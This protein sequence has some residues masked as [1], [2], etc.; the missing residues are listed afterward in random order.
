MSDLVI[1]SIK[2][3]DG[4]LSWKEPSGEQCVVDLMC[5]EVVQLPL[6][7]ERPLLKC[8]SGNYFPPL[9]YSDAVSFWSKARRNAPRK[10]G[11]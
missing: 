11:Y 3:E 6:N 10:I 1:G 4:F 5:V 9:S 7:G 8:G 2:H